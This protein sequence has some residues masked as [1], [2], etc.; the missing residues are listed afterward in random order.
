MSASIGALLPPPY[1]SSTLKGQQ[2]VSP[3][4]F[5]NLP[6]PWYFP[7]ENEP[8]YSSPFTLFN[9]PFPSSVT[10]I[11]NLFQLKDTE[12]VVFVALEKS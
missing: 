12:R 7:L 2:G 11:Q 4:S 1:A 6:N 3:S 10:L 9:L 8:S 5:N